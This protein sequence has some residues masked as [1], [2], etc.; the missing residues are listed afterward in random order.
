MGNNNDVRAKEGRC[1]GEEELMSEEAE[2]RTARS[3]MH[4]KM[5]V[6]VWS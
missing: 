5:L 4:R 2:R 6:N 3:E 1:G